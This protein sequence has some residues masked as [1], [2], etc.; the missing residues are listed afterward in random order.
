MSEPSEATKEIQTRFTRSNFCRVIRMDGAWGS[1]TPQG[2]IHMAIYN[3]RWEMPAGSTITA[4]P[5]SKLKEVADTTEGR[6]IREIEADIFLDLPTA[7]SLRNWLN[8]KIELLQA[9]K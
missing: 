6:A 7:I 3:E 4:G 2:L 5:N 8:D 1:I 9:A